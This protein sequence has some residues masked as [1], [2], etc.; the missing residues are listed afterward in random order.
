M[1]DEKMTGSDILGL[2]S[3]KEELLDKKNDNSAQIYKANDF[4]TFLGLK[5]SGDQRIVSFE[6]TEELMKRDE[7]REEDGFKKKIRMGTFPTPSGN[8]IMV[9]TVEEEKLVH[10]DFNPE[11]MGEGQGDGQGGQGE[12][13]EGD[14]IGEQPIDEEGQ[15]EDGEGQAG[16]G[17]GGEHGVETQA[18]DLAEKL[19]KD[20]DF[21]LPNQE[22]KAKKIPTTKYKY[23][24]TDKHRGSGQVLDKKATLRS[25]IKTNNGLGR[26]DKDNIDTTKMIISPRDLIYRVL[27]AER[28]FESQAIVFFVRDYS[29]SMNGPLT[30]AVVTQH[31]MIYALLMHYYKE[32]VKT[33]FILHDTEAKEVANFHVYYNSRVAG[34]TQVSSAYKMI[35]KIVEE[36]QLARDYNIYVFHGTDGDDWDTNGAQAIPELKKMMEHVNRFGL[37]IVN[38]PYTNNVSDMQKY[39]E[40]SELLKS[41]PQ[42]FKMDVIENKDFEEARLMEGIKKLFSKE[43]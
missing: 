38:S 24:L 36:E 32:K 18:Y 28:E 22:E 8:V 40:A 15:G 19:M 34:G 23:D 43:K 13:E 12:G 33:R 25:I 5:F 2:A 9:P 39:I 37:T 31:L 27:S 42:K 4:L 1:K 7:Q 6:T 26:I 30:Q 29:G 21:E 20:Y 10:I 35:N 11:K 16:D 41:Y 17:D 3:Y 14:I